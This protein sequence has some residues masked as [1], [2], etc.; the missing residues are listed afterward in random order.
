MVGKEVGWWTGGG[1]VRWW[2][3]SKWRDC[4][5]GVVL[6]VVVGLES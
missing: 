4:V 2:G 1:I 6:M 3:R 5:G